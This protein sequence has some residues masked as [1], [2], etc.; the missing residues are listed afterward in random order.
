MWQPARQVLRCAHAGL[1]PLPCIT[2]AWRPA[3]ARSCATGCRACCQSCWCSAW[4]RP[5][6]AP[7]RGCPAPAHRQCYDWSQKV[8]LGCMAGN[9]IDCDVASQ[10][11]DF[12][13]ENVKRGPPGS[14]PQ[15]QALQSPG[16]AWKTST[17]AL[18][19]S[20]GEGRGERSGRA[21]CKLM[22]AG[23]RMAALC[24]PARPAHHWPQ[25]CSGS[26]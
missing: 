14:L 10:V 20:G 7:Q 8:F 18:G 12:S 24:A 25:N 23:A 17:W 19:A 13:A 5:T 11:F 6:R 4:A 15:F 3:R 2:P 9:S 16:V 21:P 1:P 26:S 22:G